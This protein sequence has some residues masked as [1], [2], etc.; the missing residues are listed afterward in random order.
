MDHMVPV[1]SG[2]S[3]RDLEL[4]VPSNKSRLS[5]AILGFALLLAGLPICSQAAEEWPPQGTNALAAR[6]AAFFD[7]DRPGEG[8]FVEILPGGR[9]VVYVFSYGPK[10]VW[11]TDPRVIHE[12]RQT[13]FVATGTATAG[14]IYATVVQPLGG[15]FGAAFDP[16]EIE[17][18]DFGPLF[19]TYPSCGTNT[20]R[21]YFELYALG[22]FNL[23][24]QDLEFVNYVQLSHVLDCDTG[25][26]SPHSIHSGSWFDPARTGEGFVVE[27]L[28]DGRGLVQWMTYDKNG[29]QM[30]MQGLGQF[31]PD[32]QE[33]RVDDLM[34]YS[35]T[36]WGSDFVADDITASRFGSLTM[37]FSGC[38]SATVEYDSPEFGSGVQNLE[39]LTTPLH[40]NDAGVGCWDY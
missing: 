7:H 21:G 25:V 26:G 18:L 17:Y 15:H 2:C 23:D 31:D 24:Y 9:A 34:S 19:F 35:G 13:W 14:G 20:E 3:T 22:N 1:R 12:P 6:T 30:W 11:G 29:E 16:D 36:Y 27:I 4:P 32:S 8:I 5:R 33:L 28:E 40:I 38:E 37:T 10:Y 39:R